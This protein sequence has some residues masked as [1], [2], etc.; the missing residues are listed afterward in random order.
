V[1]IDVWQVKSGTIFDHILLSTD[2]ADA[3]AARKAFFDSNKDAEKAAFDAH[4]EAQKKAAAAPASSS[5][6]EDEEEKGAKKTEL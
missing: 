2:P 4:E 6:D 5:D 3:V 1:G